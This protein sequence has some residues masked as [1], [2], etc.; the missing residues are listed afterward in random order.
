MLSSILGG[1]RMIRREF[2]TLLGGAAAWPIAARGQ[3]FPTIGF[4]RNTSPDQA[5]H[6]VAAFHKGLGETGFVEGRNL[7]IEY[8]WTNGRTDRLPAMAAELAARKVSAIVA[9][10]STPAIRAAKAATATIPVV[11]MLGADPVELGLVA[12]LNRPGGNLTGVFNLNQQLAQKWL[13]VLHELVPGATTFALLVNPANTATTERYIREAQAGAAAL[14]LQ[15]EIVKA[16]TEHEL[17]PVFKRVREVRAGALMIAADLLFISHIEQL[18]ALTLRH[19]VPAIYPF[20]EFVAAGGLASYGTN[21]ADTY[22]LAGV[23]TGRILKGEKP[24]DLPVQQATK[25]ELVLNLKTAKAL[26]LTVPLPLIGRA[27]EVVE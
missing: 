22:Q 16:T 14:G 13:E 12:S 23:Y 20:R 2:M 21:L 18:G 5:A 17:D 25:V 19:A 27:D 9:L 3:Q 1:A 7:A 4:L 26:G 15:I 10:G 6:L 11:F 24:A 8:R